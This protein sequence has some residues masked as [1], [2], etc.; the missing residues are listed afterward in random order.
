MAWVLRLVERWQRVPDFFL[1]P[2]KGSETLWTISVEYS[3]DHYRFL[4]FFDAET[5]V[6]CTGVTTRRK[7]RPTTNEVA[8][9]VE[10]Q[11]DYLKRKLA[12]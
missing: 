12:S 9:A 1:K 5:F 6:I 4:G 7:Q 11:S 3:G 8:R 10:R 2:M